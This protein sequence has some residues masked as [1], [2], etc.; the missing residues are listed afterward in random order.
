MS[1]VLG[2][3]T[4]ELDYRVSTQET[5]ELVASLLPPT[6]VPRLQRLVDASRVRLRQTVRPLHE[7]RSMKTLEARNAAYK[8]EAIALGE[9][10][11]LQALSVAGVR[12]SDIDILLVTSSTGHLVPT[13]DQHLVSRLGLR[14]NVRCIPLFGLGCAGAVRAMALAAD[15]PVSSRAGASALVISVELCSL[16]LQVAEPS[17]DDVLS[18]IFFAD[19]AGAA[20]IGSGRPGQTPELV[21]SYNELWPGSLE[22]RGAR[23]TE[24]GFRHSCSSKLPLL[25]RAKLQETVK[26]FLRRQGL[27][28]PDLRFY[29]INP[30]DHRI[31]QAV[32]SILDLPEPTL[33]PAWRT[34]EQRGNT[35]SAG[36]LYV[37]QTLEALAAPAD[38]DLGLV[39]V[40]G[41]GIT[42]E[43]LLLRWHGSLA[44][45]H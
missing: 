23:L 14:P 9:R 26:E 43:M 7:L 32:G 3:S 18:N 41:P 12:P 22:A 27:N 15:L 40:F 31:L 17:P 45:G 34:W 8:K 21:A 24:T 20:V 10:V 30:S 29:A 37:L 1:Q 5:K 4:G 19:G 35:L 13:L 16:W 6:E 2:L 39:L 25:L 36:P 44:R 33:C 11:G 28:T 42:C 38:G